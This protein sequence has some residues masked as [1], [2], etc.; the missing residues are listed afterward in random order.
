VS[1]ITGIGSINELD[2]NI[3]A[4]SQI[5]SPTYGSPI[6]SA[7]VERD[8]PLW[9]KVQEILGSWLNF[10]FIS[11]EANWDVQQQKL[12]KLKL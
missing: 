10:N 9:S 1:T 8:A 12:V 6:N 4:I 5:L 3:S 7:R 2:E 11:P